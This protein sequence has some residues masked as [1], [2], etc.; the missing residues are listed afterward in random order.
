VSFRLVRAK[1][2]EIPVVVEVPHAGLRVDPVSLSLCVA[3]ARSIGRDADLFVDELYSDAPSVGASLIV[4]EMSRYVCDLNRDPTDLDRETSSVGRL[5]G[6]AY[7]VIWRKST[8][9]YRALA[10][11]ISPDE[12]ERRLRDYYRPY[13]EALSQLLEEKKKRFGYVFLLCAHSMPSLGRGGEPRAD[14]VPGSRAG[15]STDP[16]LLETLELAATAAG[17]S[18]RH[19]DPYRGGFSTEHYGR[20]D[21]G[22]HALQVELARRLYMDET[23][24]GRTRNFSTLR[25]FC[26]DLVKQ[27]GEKAQEI[28]GSPGEQRLGPGVARVERQ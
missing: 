16:R 8:E 27:L 7:G 1:G 2:Q 22:E 25:G 28:F 3:P 9:G 24:L 19:D 6:S 5:D 26:R 12:V 21:R 10:G 4:A 13:H 11:E 20:P 18:V 23:T 14:I 15:T 17:Y